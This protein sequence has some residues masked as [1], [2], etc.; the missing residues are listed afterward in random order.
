MKY[1]L[2]LLDLYYQELEQVSRDN[3]D[4][5]IEKIKKEKS[6]TGLTLEM[7]KTPDILAEVKGD[8]IRVGFAAESEDLIANARQKL[9]KKQLDLIA[10][11][12]ITATDSGFGVDTNKV[13]LIDRTGGTENLPLMTKR[14]VADKILDKVTAMLSSR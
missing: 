10:A 2:N 12:D 13:T 11:N 14:E 9:E 3:L 7:V 5:A 4:K 6:G 8:F 1:N